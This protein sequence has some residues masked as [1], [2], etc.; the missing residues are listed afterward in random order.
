MSTWTRSSSKTSQSKSLQ[1]LHPKKCEFQKKQIKYLE[2]VI[3]ENK[4]SIDSVKIA[5]VCKWPIIENWTGIQAFLGFINFYQR[6]T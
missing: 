5:R 2:L 1:F 4:V 6:F 3:S